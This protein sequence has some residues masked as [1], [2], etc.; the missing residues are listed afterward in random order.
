MIELASQ[1]AINLRLQ[2]KY[3]N[4]E[5]YFLLSKGYFFRREAFL[6]TINHPLFWKIS[7]VVYSGFRPKRK[8]IK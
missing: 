1:D 8:D 4:A 5:T 3:Q 2:L 7:E 6:A